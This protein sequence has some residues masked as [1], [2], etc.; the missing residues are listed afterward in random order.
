MSKIV[1][2]GATGMIANSLTNYALSLGDEVVAIVHP[3]SKR[4]SSVPQGAKIIKCDLRDL[5]DLKP[6]FSADI[7]FHLGWDKTSNSGRDDALSQL[8]NV[9]Y[10][11]EAVHLAKR[12]GCHSFVGAGSQA[13]Y[14]IVS[15][16]INGSTPVNPESGYGISKYTAGKMCALVAS[17]LK[18]KFNWARIISIYGKNDNPN[19]LISY[20]ISSFKNGETPNLTKCE[21]IWDYMHCDDC[22][23]AIYL[24]GQKGV[25][26]KTYVLGSGEKRKLSS[27]VLAVKN[28]IDPNATIN[29]GAKEYYAHQP[30]YL[31]ADVAD[32]KNDLNFE[33]EYTFEQGIEKTLKGE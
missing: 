9:E 25:D 6:D 18:I 29:F 16:D 22:A 21:Q 14:G 26:G 17:Q 1:I 20:L 30:M 23:R 12:L 10:S 7:F 8:K 27:Y 28:A 32:L 13:E 24:I 11:I 3:N 31:C 4:I 5:I 2:T 19:S 15:G 33:C